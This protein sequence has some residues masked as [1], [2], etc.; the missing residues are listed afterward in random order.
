MYEFIVEYL[1]F[2]CELTI[3][4]LA[5]VCKIIT[6]LMKMNVYPHENSLYNPI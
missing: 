3:N 4:I 5:N 6:V 2:A 1:P